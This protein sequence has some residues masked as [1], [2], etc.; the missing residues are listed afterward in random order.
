M[1]LCYRPDNFLHQQHKVILLFTN[2]EIPPIYLETEKRWQVALI[3]QS[4]FINLQAGGFML[5]F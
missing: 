2:D 1:M 3:R 5:L 4:H